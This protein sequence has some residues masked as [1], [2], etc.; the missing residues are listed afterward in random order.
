[1]ITTETGQVEKALEDSF[2]QCRAIKEMS[3]EGVLGTS[4]MP[5]VAM[6]PEAQDISL[7][8]GQGLLAA[9]CG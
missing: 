5:R 8:Q 4:H 1:M 6:P 3:V 2:A 7:A 9:A